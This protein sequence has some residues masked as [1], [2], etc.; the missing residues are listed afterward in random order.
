MTPEAVLR[1]AVMGFLAW[2]YLSHYL[3]QRSP[4]LILE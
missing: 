2:A 1:P 4:F 3:R